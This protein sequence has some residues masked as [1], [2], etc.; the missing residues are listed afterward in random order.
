MPGALVRDVL[1]RVSVL[2]KDTS[3]QFEGWSLREMLAWLND[4]QRAI[5][6]YVPIAGAR[7]DVIKL[8]AGALQAIDLIAADSILPGNGSTP[9][10]VRGLSLNEIVCNMGADGA[11]PGTAVS[12]VSRDMLESFDR[13]WRRAASGTSGI[14]H[15]MFDPR[16]PTYFYVYPPAD[17]TGWV[18]ASII[19][20]PDDVPMPLVEADLGMDGTGTQETAIDARWQDDLVN[21]IAAR[22]WMKDSQDAANAQAV[23]LY[24]GMFINSI[25]AQV[26]AL[27]GQ[28]PNLKHLPFAADVPG[29]AS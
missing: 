23:Q 24:T 17:G 21:Y 10:D 11:T 13:N 7:R 19:A 22:A 15:F 16:T 12:P 28:N 1:Y 14:K 18:E 6:K 2:L 29:A 25:N 5:A 3:P 26:Q 20:A 4:G 8:R 27:T 9:A